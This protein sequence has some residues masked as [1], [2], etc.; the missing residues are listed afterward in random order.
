[1]IFTG[2]NLTIKRNFYTQTGNIGLDMNCSVDNTT[3]AYHFGLSGI[4]GKQDFLLQSGKLYQGTTFLHTY[5]SNI[6]FNLA[7][8]CSSG[9]TNIIKDGSTLS[10]GSP[11]STGLFDYFYFTRENAGMGAAFDLLISG[12]DIPIY[13]IQNQGYLLYSG[14]NAV[15]G[16]FTNSSNYPIKV[17]DSSMLATQNYSFG[18]LVSTINGSN[19]GAFAYSGD[20][21]LI[22]IND[23]ILTTFNTNFGDIQQLFYITDAR[24]L[25][26]FIY[27]TSPNDFT[28]NGT[29]VLNRTLSYLNY[30]GGF[31]GANFPTYL[32]FELDYVSGS[33]FFAPSGSTVNF[34]TT[35]YGN[36]L[37]SGLLTGLAS[38]TTGNII[39]SS[40]AWATGLV[41]G[42]FSGLGT[43]MASGL[44]FT[45]IV[46]GQYTGMYTGTIYGGSGTLNLNS[47]LVGVGIGGYNTFYTG[48]SYATGYLDLGTM[49]MDAGDDFFINSI[50][51]GNVRFIG[52]Y[53]SS[54][55]G[56]SSSGPL[57]S[58]NFNNFN[59]LVQC[60]SGVTGSLG[61]TAYVIQ[62]S[63]LFFTSLYAGTTGNHIFLNDDGG[64]WPGAGFLTGGA[65]GTIAG[66]GIM[67]P[68]SPYTGK[69]NIIITGSGNYS[70]I[71][72]GTNS[73]AYYKTFSGSWNFMSGI[74][75]NSLI[76]MNN[77][78]SPN[79]MT[80]AALFNP[81]SSI[82]FQVTHNIIDSNQ[83]A[84]KL[85]ISGSSVLNPIIQ[86][87]IN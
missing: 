39:V 34:L 66:S 18:K 58:S 65:S 47:N 23:P 20:Y 77:G 38:T 19:S 46:G 1:M 69:L 82:I 8:Q 28:F 15:T 63:G 72:S 14:Q 60:I 71:I 37:K 12:D 16:Q 84:A 80:G 51:G 42:L 68:L 59:T 5:N 9:S 24:T 52:T 85:I 64:G 32:T 49:T 31:A 40:F 4:Q 25:N 11:K 76:S 21:S 43:G 35:G 75:Q 83:D 61:V 67:I 7:I 6:S 86:T 10:F 13:S 26:K 36:F 17:F 55:L 27:F 2:T 29:G 57:F 22:N 87:L 81:N 48:Q 73:N 33:G 3:G 70:N 53:Q 30:S 56:C 79:K 44:G 54:A 41:T 45:G 50:S 78:S 62:P 74:D